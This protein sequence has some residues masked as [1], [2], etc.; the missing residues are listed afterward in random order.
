[1][2][3]NMPVKT[4]KKNSKKSAVKKTVKK[5][6]KKTVTVK[7]AAK[8]SGVSKAATV[9]KTAAKPVIVPVSAVV[10]VP[11]AVPV[12][13]GSVPAVKTMADVIWD[14]IKNRPIEMFALPNQ[15]VSMHC[16]PVKVEPSKLYLLIRSTATLPSLE[17]SIGAAFSVSVVDKY[18]VVFRAAAVLTVK[19]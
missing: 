15:T 17:A 6:V 14:E 1:M 11:V 10:P 2:E 13:V 7:K 19:K 5:V 9:V 8:K 4:A 16:A 3:K 18:V 12:Q